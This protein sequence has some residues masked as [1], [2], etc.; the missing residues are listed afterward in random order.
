MYIEMHSTFLRSVYRWRQKIRK[1]AVEILQN[2][3]NQTQTLRQVLLW[4]PFVDKKRK[5]TATLPPPIPGI[6]RSTSLKILGVTTSSS[7]S[8]ADP[9]HN[10][11]HTIVTS[12]SQTL[13][14]LTG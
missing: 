5:L 6:S 8:L 9:I 11:I 7:L 1:I 12:C 3:N 2:V 13:H 4:L 14:A 10:I